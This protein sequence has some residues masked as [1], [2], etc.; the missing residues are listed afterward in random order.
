M[1]ALGA[2]VI[3]TDLSIIEDLFMRNLNNNRNIVKSKV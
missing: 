3:A 2:N 1:G